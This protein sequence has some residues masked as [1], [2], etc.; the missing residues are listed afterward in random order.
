MDQAVDSGDTA[1]RL[2]RYDE[3]GRKF[4]L[5]LARLGADAVPLDQTEPTSEGIGSICLTNHPDSD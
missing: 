3:M 5:F 1:A 4:R 2:Q